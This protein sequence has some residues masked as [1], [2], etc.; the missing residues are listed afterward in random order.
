MMEDMKTW[1][2]ARQYCRELGGDLSS[3]MSR[4]HQGKTSVRDFSTA[5]NDE[6]INILSY[7]VHGKCDIILKY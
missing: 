1:T 3:V 4:T 5:Q 2:E 6:C 7:S